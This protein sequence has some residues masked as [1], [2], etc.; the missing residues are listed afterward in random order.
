M[1]EERQV[2]LSVHD[3]IEMGMARSMAYQ[4]LNRADLPVI[5]I[6]IRKF[7]LRDL[8]LDWLREQALGTSRRF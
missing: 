3:L 6:G 7:M 1:S 8:F 5:Q 2:L 4:L